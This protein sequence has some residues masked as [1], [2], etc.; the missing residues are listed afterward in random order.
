M[1]ITGTGS[2][3]PAFEITND[4]LAEFLDTSDEWI[5][6]R[7]GIKS[8]RILKD[9]SLRDLALTASIKALEN[10]GLAAGDLDFI[11]CSTVMGDYITP[12]LSCILQ[13]DLG[14]SCACVDI[15]CACA[16]FINALDIA[17][18]YIATGRAKRILIICAEA[19]SRFCDWTDRSSCIL[20]GDGAAAVIVEEGEGLMAT[21]LTTKGELDS[22]YARAY[23]GNCPYRPD[24]GGFEG[25]Q[26][27]GQ[28]VYR[29]AVSTSSDDLIKILSEASISADQVDHYLLHQA[30]LRIIKA[31]QTRLKV[32]PEKVRHNIERTGNTSSVTIPLLMDEMN[33]EGALKPGQI[34]AMSAFGAGLTTGACLLK[35]T[36]A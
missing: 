12:G 31:I 35:W 36:K 23:P 6:S 17:D 2:A 34:L 5:S 19:V 7:T 14:A 18:A 11:I 24:E 15:N 28:E 32:S 1:Q 10:A 33:R 16:G 3:Q 13:G 9:E 20:F 30:N 4:M 8:R 22:L 21:R 27:L 26:M 25:M 29:F